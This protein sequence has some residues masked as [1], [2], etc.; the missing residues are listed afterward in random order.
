[1][2]KPFEG[3]TELDGASKRQNFSKNLCR[4]QERLTYWVRN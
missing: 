1:M 3:F 2:G 4:A